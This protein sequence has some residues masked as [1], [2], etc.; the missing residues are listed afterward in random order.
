MS[1]AVSISDYDRASS[2][3]DTVRGTRPPTREL[4]VEM[5]DA[6][7]GSGFTNMERVEV[8]KPRVRTGVDFDDYFV[9]PPCSPGAY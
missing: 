4:K 9:S 6:V 1:A 2:N 3:A 7:Y 8:I 5:G